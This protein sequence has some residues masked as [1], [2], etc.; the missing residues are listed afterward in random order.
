MSSDVSDPRSVKRSQRRV[1]RRS[2]SLEYGRFT[3]N[4]LKISDFLLS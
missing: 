4:L 2:T 1:H 3:V